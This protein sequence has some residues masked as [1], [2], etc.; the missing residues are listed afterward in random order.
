MNL[1]F[2]VLNIRVGEERLVGLVWVESSWLMQS[3]SLRPIAPVGDSKILEKS[4]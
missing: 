2:S 4:I 3:A 1:L